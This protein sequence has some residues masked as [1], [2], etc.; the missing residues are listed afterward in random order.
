MAAKGDPDPGLFRETSAAQ[1][2]TPVE[3]LGMTFESEEARRE[4]FLARLRERLPE[5]RQRP[6][7]P[8]AEDEDILRLCDPPYYTA[9]PN[10]FLA[11][12]V[13]HYQRGLK[14]P[15]RL[16]LPDRL[17]LRDLDVQPHDLE[18]YDAI[19]RNTP[20]DTGD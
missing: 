4:Y 17:G 16:T 7:F 20:D 1:D 10:P 15:L 3:C 5:L 19:G 2:S 8:V 9:C 6:D 12:F 18:T 13:E 14:P 11:E